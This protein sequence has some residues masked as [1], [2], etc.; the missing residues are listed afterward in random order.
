MPI[1]EITDCTRPELSEYTALTH[2]QLRRMTD[3]PHG[4]LIAESRYT[5]QM[6]RAHSRL[7]LL[8][9]LRGVAAVTVHRR[10]GADNAS[11][12]ALGGLRFRLL[13]RN[14]LRHEYGFPLGNSGGDS[15]LFTCRLPRR[16][17][18]GSRR[19]MERPAG[20]HTPMRIYCNFQPVGVRYRQHDP[21]DN[22]VDPCAFPD[23]AVLA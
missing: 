12:H 15:R 6:S 4:V 23:G 8:L 3:A 11:G 20:V 22:P 17:V 9:Y 21:G 14:G 19:N 13:C 7:C 16:H 2:A 5:M 1:V 18:Y 10:R